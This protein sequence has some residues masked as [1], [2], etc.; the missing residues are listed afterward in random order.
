MTQELT[1]TDT[2]VEDSI[3]P[4]MHQFSYNCALL[5]M[6][7]LFFLQLLRNEPVH[8]C[9]TI[10]VPSLRL[11]SPF[12]A[13]TERFYTIVQVEIL[14]RFGKTFDWALKSKMIGKPALDAAKIFIDE[15]GL[16]GE[17]TPEGFLEEREGMLAELFPDANLLP[18][19]DRL[20]RHLA[21]KRVPMAVATR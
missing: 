20:V 6:G 18:G 2:R 15:T 19:V 17:L 12:P 16:Q 21:A 5:S 4:K 1:R 8:L 9:A 11:T 10:N 3:E 7:H 13:D 14:K